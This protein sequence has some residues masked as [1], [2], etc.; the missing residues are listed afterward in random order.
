LD[1]TPKSTG[2]SAKFT[3]ILRAFASTFIEIATNQKHPTFSSS[4]IGKLIRP[5]AEKGDV[6][7]VGFVDITHS[8][9]DA[10]DVLSL[11]SL[12]R[13]HLKRVE[14]KGADTKSPLKTPRG[15]SGK[16][17]PDAKGK[18]TIPGVKSPPTKTRPDSAK[19]TRPGTASKLGKD[20]DAAKD[21]D[22]GKDLT[23]PRKT[24]DPETL[25]SPRKEVPK[26]AGVHDKKPA[27]KKDGS[28]SP[29]KEHGKKS[30][31]TGV[32]VPDNK[33]VKKL[34]GGGHHKKDD[35]TADK[36]GADAAHKKDETPKTDD[37]KDDGAKKA[38]DSHKKG[39]EDKKDTG[40]KDG[41]TGKSPITKRPG[42]AGKT[43]K[44]ASPKKEHGKKEHAAA[45]PGTTGS[46]GKKEHGK[47]VD[48]AAS[49]KKEGAKKVDH[50]KT[51]K[52]NGVGSPP[53]SSAS[54][55][56]RPKSAAKHHAPAATAAH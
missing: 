46:P 35:K 2:S 22:A 7:V 10:R 43:G 51:D 32:K 31:H 11:C 55:T 30:P 14:T 47:K 52:T 44:T 5:V 29:R 42:T 45:T 56:T 8:A 27:D 20:K 24:K 12:G 13:T 21:K 33:G 26:G 15:T 4:H 50:K 37:K 39:G 25:K 9:T 49:P 48:T 54:T 1:L 18:T 6:Y 36:S 38:E 41:V 3:Q 53:P 23:S 19:I 16:S 40:K 17:S 34:M 28:T